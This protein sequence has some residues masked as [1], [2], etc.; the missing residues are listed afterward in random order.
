M[1][2]S[3]NLPPGTSDEV[4]NAWVDA[5]KKI[6]ADPEFMAKSGKIFGSYPQTLGKAAIPIRDKATTISPEARAWLAKYLKSRHDVEIA[7]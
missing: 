6:L 2:K 5:T 1:S 4:L 3:L 7:L